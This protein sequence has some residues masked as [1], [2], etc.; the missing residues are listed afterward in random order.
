M[1]ICSVTA[2]K[3][4]AADSISIKQSDKVMA[5]D[6]SLQTCYN[7]MICSNKRALVLVVCDKCVCDERGKAI[8]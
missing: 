6:C 4:G 1:D 5:F 8:G 2:E 3:S 7:E